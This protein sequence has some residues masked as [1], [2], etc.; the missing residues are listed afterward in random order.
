MFGLMNSGRECGF[1]GRT[2]LRMAFMLQLVENPSDAGV[3]VG[4]DS[5]SAI[6]QEIEAIKPTGTEEFFPDWLDSSEKSKPIS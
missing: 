5:I 3:G 1:P 4:L 6:V 2:D